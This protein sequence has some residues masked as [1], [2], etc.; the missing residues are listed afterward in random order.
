MA[1]DILSEFAD[2]EEVLRTYLQDR[3]GPA[4]AVV[5]ATGPVLTPPTVKA[6]R[7]GGTCD[8]ITDFSEML[9]STFGATRTASIVLAAQVQA[10]IL[11]ATNTPVPLSNGT[12]ALIDGAHISQAD[13]PELY[14]NPDVRHVI[15]TFEL[16]MRRPK[17]AP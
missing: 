7:I 9:V 3:L 11:N 1:I 8:R 4:V 5:S 6:Q 10:H 15:A 17:P 13:H 16:R 14:A 12:V 2:A